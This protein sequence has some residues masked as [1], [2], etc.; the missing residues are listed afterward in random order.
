MG[1][2]GLLQGKLYLNVLAILLGSYTELEHLPSSEEPFPLLVL[3][4]QIQYILHLN[5][6]NSF[7]F[8][9]LCVQTTKR[10]D[11]GA[12]REDL[13]QSD[14]CYRKS[15]NDIPQDNRLCSSYSYVD[16]V[17][18][19]RNR[20]AMGFIVDVSEIL[21]ISIINTKSYFNSSNI[22]EN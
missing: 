21:T 17:L 16:H 18:G 19:V 8:S 1:L 3:S 2:H 15:H 14:F 9:E 10:Q 13:P 11:T 22:L 5:C 4:C 6:S 7:D 12:H 20:V